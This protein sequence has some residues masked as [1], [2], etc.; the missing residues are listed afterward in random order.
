MSGLVYERVHYNLETLKLT[1]IK[2]MLDNSLEHAAKEGKSTLEILDYLLEQ[3]VKSKQ[4]HAL[5]IRMRMASFPVEKRLDDFDVAFQPSLDPLIIK[6]LASLR[7]IHNAE[8]VVFLGPPGVGK[9]HLAVA[10]GYEAVKQG[11]RVYYANAS[12]LIE[13]LMKAN[14]ENKLE[15]KIK[16]LTKFH[17]LIIDEMGYL[18]FTS[19]GAHCFFQ[20]ISRRYEKSST[21]FTSNKSFGEWGEIFGDHVIAAAVLDRILHHCTTLNIKGDSYR[22]KERRRQ[23]LIPHV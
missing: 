7:F 12:Q 10:L 11:F 14:R 13:R 20:L 18:P 3:E 19:E 23:G 2:E 17:L 1:T 15:E 4:D 21:I 6:D 16:A 8:N 9:T 22:L 5:S